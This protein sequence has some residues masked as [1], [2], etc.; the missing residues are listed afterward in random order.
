MYGK[1]LQPV[2]PLV[3]TLAKCGEIVHIVACQAHSGLLIVKL[4]L[5]LARLFHSNSLLVCTCL[6]KVLR[7]LCVCHK[8]LVVDLHPPWLD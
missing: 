3:H 2:S 1:G 4:G 7:T 6:V 8:Y 5:V